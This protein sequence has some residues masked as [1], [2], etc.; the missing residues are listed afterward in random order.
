MNDTFNVIGAGLAGCE[1][2]NYLSKKGMHINLY[3]MKPEHHTEA[4]KSDLF[5][6]LVCSNSLKNSSVTTA[7]G[8]LKFEM[9]LLGSLILESGLK[10]S[11][12]AGS[13]LA[14]DREG[15]SKYITE[16]LSN[17]KN[18]TVINKRI[19]SIRS[20]IDDKETNTI[21]C[22][23]PLTT[24]ELANDLSD[25]TGKSNLF[26]F[27]AVS[28][29]VELEDIDMGNA[30]MASRYGKGEA[31]YINC[32]FT[33]DEYDLFYNYVINADTAVLKDFENKKVFE[34]CMPFEILAK[35][36]IETLRFGPMKPIG[37]TNPHKPELDH[38]VLQLR[39]DNKEATIYDLVGFQ[40]NLTFPAQRELM[41]YIPALKNAHIIRYG[42]MHKNIYLKAPDVLNKY[43]QMKEYNNIFFGGQISGVEG[44][45]ESA[46]SGLVAA[47]NALR[48]HQN[49]EMI[50][51]TRETMIGSLQ[52][53]ISNSTISNFQPMNANYGIVE[54]LNKHY[55]TKKLKYEMMAQ[56]SLDK[57]KE[58]IG[59]NGI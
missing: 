49:Q 34:S 32:P 23:G 19:D 7:C 48:K 45:M 27:D 22:T 50:D 59:S 55:K 58:I 30:Y 54:P 56:R 14:V 13:A 43:F 25:I 26:F 40:T 18:I 6:E 10:N 11:L 38:A 29:S 15:F 17:D 1:A 51:F 47:I 20:F 31:A 37:L 16:K 9:S 4:H 42:V 52:N 33:K 12:P 46:V 21:I 24:L 2:A 41:R 44:Y 36:G 28:P 5:S 53:Y 35:R 39:Q 3:E 8:L 57:I